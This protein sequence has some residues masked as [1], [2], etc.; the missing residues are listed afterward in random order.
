MQKHA[1][2]QTNVNFGYSST[3]TVISIM[4]QMKTERKTIREK[5]VLIS[6]FM[7]SYF[8]TRIKKMNLMFIHLKKHAQI[9]NLNLLFHL[10]IRR[11]LNE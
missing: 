7:Q 4:N 2:A 1:N 8:Q 11:H 10:F 3:S 9:E 5:E 6:T